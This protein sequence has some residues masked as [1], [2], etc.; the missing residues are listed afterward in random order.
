MG[1]GITILNRHDKAILTKV[2]FHRDMKAVRLIPEGKARGNSLSKGLEIGM[3]L[4]D[5]LT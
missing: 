1:V 4:S 3:Y 2:K 5:S